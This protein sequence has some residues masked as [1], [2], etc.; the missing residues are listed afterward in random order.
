M[1]ES[2]RNMGISIFSGTLTTVG[3]G[4]F[5]FGGVL[6]TFQKF[7]LIITC[8][9]GC[10]FFTSMLLFGALMHICGPQKGMGDL[11]YSCRDRDDEEGYDLD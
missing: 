10:S 6:V 5:L 7:A 3:A 4:A 9:I 8:T 1:R 2:F 11:C